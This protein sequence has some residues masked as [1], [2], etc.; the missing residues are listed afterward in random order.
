MNQLN[1]EQALVEIY[2]EEVKVLKTKY[3]H[4]PNGDCTSQCR[5]TGCPSDEIPSFEEWLEN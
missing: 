3:P 1:K 5:R 2:E 4:T